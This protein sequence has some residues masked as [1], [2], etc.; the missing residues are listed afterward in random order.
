MI[1]AKLD[2]LLSL[3]NSVGVDNEGDV[4]VV[5][6]RE[7]RYDMVPYSEERQHC[8]TAM[9]FPHLGRTSFR[10]IRA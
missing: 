8:E 1:I 3:G 9:M 4:S 6:P 7:H 10:V 2:V 5:A